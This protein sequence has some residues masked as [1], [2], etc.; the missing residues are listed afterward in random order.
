M[1]TQAH[2]MDLHDEMFKAANSVT[3]LY[4]LIQAD[5]LAKKNVGLLG[6]LV[7][8]GRAPMHLV[9]GMIHDINKNLKQRQTT[10][11]N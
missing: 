7:D 3:G 2:Y 1:T 5:K 4:E 8:A 11:F 9:V 6:E 10:L